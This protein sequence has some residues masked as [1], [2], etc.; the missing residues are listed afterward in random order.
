MPKVDPNDEKIILHG[1]I[2]M[3]KSTIEISK[4]TFLDLEKIIFGF[5]LM[6][7]FTFFLNL[8]QSYFSQQNKEKRKLNI[9][10]NYFETEG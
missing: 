6:L 10:Q 4:I 2:Y 7:V 5:I 9:V 8:I 1:Q 3:D